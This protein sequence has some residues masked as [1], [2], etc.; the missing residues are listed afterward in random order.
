[1]RTQIVSA[2]TAKSLRA[3]DYVFSPRHKAKEV[4]DAFVKKNPIIRRSAMKALEES[5]VLLLEEALDAQRPLCAVCKMRGNH[6][7]MCPVG[8]RLM[9]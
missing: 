8:L 1:M 4:L 3:S 5:L 6:K 9:K 7:I 2:V